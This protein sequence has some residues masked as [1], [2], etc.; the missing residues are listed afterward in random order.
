[1][2]DLLATFNLPALKLFRIRRHLSNKNH[3]NKR[4]FTGVQASY[5]S[6][7]S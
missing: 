3:P 4:L 6:V 2:V 5:T 7:H 1:M